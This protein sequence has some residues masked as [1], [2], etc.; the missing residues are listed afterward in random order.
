M[1]NKILLASILCTLE[2]TIEKTLNSIE[3]YEI[4]AGAQNFKLNLSSNTASNSLGLLLDNNSLQV[5]A[6][7]PNLLADSAGVK[8]N[9]VINSIKIDDEDFSPTDKA[10]ADKLKFNSIMQ[11]DVSRG[12]ENKILKAKK[13]TNQ[14][15]DTLDWELNIEKVITASAVAGNKQDAC[16]QIN[17]FFTPI[18]NKLQYPVLILEIDGKSVTNRNRYKLKPGK[19]TIKLN[20]LI[21]DSF[22]SLK[23]ESKRERFK[24][25]TLEITVEPNK[26]YEL[27]AQY[28]KR[29]ERSSE[30]K[31]QYWEPIV[32][33]TTDKLCK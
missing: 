30:N 10:L 23:F 26:T 14:D 32:W 21:N 18:T 11:F 33:R 1:K 29:Q 13:A 12:N 7:T 25:Q 31:K 20:E 4:A 15:L 24:A 9:D 6:V 22:Y 19:H 16:G 3:Q 17:Q 5:L 8:K 27:A 28:I 2:S